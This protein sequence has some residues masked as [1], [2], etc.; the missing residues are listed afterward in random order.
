M[1]MKMGIAKRTVEFIE[2]IRLCF[3]AFDICD[4]GGHV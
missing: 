3:V 2:S 1:G 4:M